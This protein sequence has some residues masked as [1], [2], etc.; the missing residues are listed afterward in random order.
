MPSYSPVQDDIPAEV[1]RSQSNELAQARLAGASLGQAQW[2]ASSA[3]QLQR[4]PGAAT[5]ATGILLVF[6]QRE[7]AGAEW[8]LKPQRMVRSV[9]GLGTQPMTRIRARCPREGRYCGEEGS[10]TMRT[11]SLPSCSTTTMS[12][13]HGSVDHNKSRNIQ[14]KTNLRQTLLLLPGKLSEI[15]KT[16]MS[17]SPLAGLRSLLPM[18]ALCGLARAWLHGWQHLA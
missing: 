11:K 3:H 14:T 13:N 17:F 2:E 7:L 15:C 12:L 1:I 5:G 18:I 10:P 8:R 6:V 16:T 4:F 9:D